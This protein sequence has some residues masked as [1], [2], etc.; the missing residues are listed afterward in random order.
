MFSFIYGSQVVFPSTRHKGRPFVFRGIVFITN[1][2]DDVDDDEHLIII[3]IQGM[4]YEASL[5][6]CPVVKAIVML[7]FKFILFCCL[8]IIFLL[9]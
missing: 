4:P 7:S 8:S 9:M 2:D 1:E 6:C 3:Q 5:L